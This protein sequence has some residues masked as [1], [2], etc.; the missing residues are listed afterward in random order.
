[1]DYG[2]AVK[3]ARRAIGNYMRDR[4]AKLARWRMNVAIVD[5]VYAATGGDA[6]L[7]PGGPTRPKTGRAPPANRLTPAEQAVIVELLLAWGVKTQNAAYRAVAEAAGYLDKNTVERS[8]LDNRE[9]AK[10]QRARAQERA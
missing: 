8:Y 2:E 1:M 3:L 7:S 4:P 9:L 5:A 6:P 10:A